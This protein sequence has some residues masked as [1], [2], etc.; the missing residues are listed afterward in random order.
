M[1][2]PTLEDIR[3]AKAEL[4]RRLS[5]HADFAGAGIGQNDG[6]F[7]VR[8]NWRALPPEADRPRRVGNVAVTH[9]EVGTI[10][11]QSED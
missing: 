5:G 10:R 1:E 4:I 7:V 11:A 2:E 8:V 6:R 3:K 9:H